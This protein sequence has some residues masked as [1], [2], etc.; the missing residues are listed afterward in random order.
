MST[1]DAGA[2]QRLSRAFRNAAKALKNAKMP[3]KREYS[4]RTAAI[5]VNRLPT[6][7]KISASL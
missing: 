6:P 2:N 3:A 7:V 4:S 1:G 5:A